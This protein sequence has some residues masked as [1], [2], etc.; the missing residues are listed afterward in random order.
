MV[1]VS[2]DHL[3]TANAGSVTYGQTMQGLTVLHYKFIVEDSQTECHR[4]LPLD[5]ARVESRTYTTC[6]LDW[7]LV[8]VGAWCIGCHHVCAARRRRLYL[9]SC[10]LQDLVCVCECVV[11]GGQSRLAT[12]QIWGRLVLCLVSAIGYSIFLIGIHSA[13]GSCC[14]TGLAIR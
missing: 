12:K 11:G 14:P 3:P 2:I 10:Q 9:N 13:L 1:N 7:L 6:V 5:P 8:A 4:H